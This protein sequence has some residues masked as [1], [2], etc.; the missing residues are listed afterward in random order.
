[1]LEGDFVGQGDGVAGGHGNVFGKATVAVFAQHRTPD[2]ELL[3]A[4]AAIAAIAAG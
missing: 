1:M 2:A 3:V 4:G